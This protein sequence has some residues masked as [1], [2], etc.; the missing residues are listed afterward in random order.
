MLENYLEENPSDAK[1]IV[2]KVILAAQARHA[3]RKAREM[4]QRKT[5]MSGEVYQV[6][7]LTVL[8]K[9]RHYVKSFWL[10]EIQLVVLQSKEETVIFRP[11][12]L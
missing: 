3:A 6:N 1:T 8:N 12:F 10:K 7:Y 5:V 9:T 2:D 11:Y 4:I